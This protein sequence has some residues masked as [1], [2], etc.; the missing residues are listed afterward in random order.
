MMRLLVVLAAL[1][2]LGGVARADDEFA[3][4]S[5]IF[6]RGTSLYRVD[7]K[8]KGETEI[9]TLASKA[10]VRALRTDAAGDTLLADVGGT[11]AWMRLDGSTKTLTD[12]PCA[13]GPAQLAEDGACVL[14][15]G[16]KGSIIV[17][18]GTGKSYPVE[19]PAPGTRLI[20]ADHERELVWADKTGVWSA[21]VADA[22]KKI[23]VAP[24]APLRYFLPS[25]D[26]SH[27]LGIFADEVYTDAHHKKPAEILMSFAL[28]GQGAR[29]KAIKSGVPVEWSHD[30]SYV[31]VQD[32]GSACL[33]RATG[34][35]Y[36]CFKGFTAA[37]IAADG[38]W[39][40]VLGAR[41][42]KKA[43]PPP[44]PAAKKPAAKPAEP[45]DEPEETG[46]SPEDTT[47]VIVA[48]PSGPLALYRAKLDGPYTEAPVLIVKI[49]D[50][51]AVWIPKAP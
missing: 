44:T 4:V 35:E 28:D 40:L 1:A 11:W 37:S 21:P 39:G 3:G 38:K 8:G 23:Q 49:V 30:S 27:A 51:A 43:P 17:N 32:N 48:P 47:D 34:G 24:D 42:P 16:A 15:R 46:T 36:K 10:I 13:D 12:L 18:L 45:A 5:V 26:G 41:D 31:L 19:I 25:P 50:G 9:A 6:A 22:K 20:G 2:C 14:C 29:R 33:M 7:A